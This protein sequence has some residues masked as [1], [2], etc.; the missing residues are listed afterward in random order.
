M[1]LCEKFGKH[2]LAVKVIDTAR[3]QS[4]IESLPDAYFEINGEDRVLS[5]YVYT[6]TIARSLFGIEEITY[7]ISYYQTK[8]K[9]LF[10]Q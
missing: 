8:N 7:S 9:Q 1:Y 6:D 3:Q 2:L 4:I 5:L 10:I